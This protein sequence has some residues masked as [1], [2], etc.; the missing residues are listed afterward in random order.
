MCNLTTL[1]LG[2]SANF[3]GD[4]CFCC[5]VSALLA[6]LEGYFNK[7]FNQFLSQFIVV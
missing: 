5:T 3:S 4:R 6:G 7:S 2:D 1:A